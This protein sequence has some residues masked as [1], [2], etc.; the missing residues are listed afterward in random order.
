MKY[1]EFFWKHIDTLSSDTSL[2]HSFGEKVWNHQQ[3]EIDRLKAI[4]AEALAV[5]DRPM[6][7]E[8][9][10]YQRDDDIWH[11]LTENKFI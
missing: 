1:N 10:L 2:A 3:Q 5:Y 9:A 8:T 7:D 6:C 4:I 11:I